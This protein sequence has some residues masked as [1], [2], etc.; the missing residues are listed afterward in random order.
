MS[1]V[2]AV[3]TKKGKI[4][5]D[6]ERYRS[7]GFWSKALE[8]ILA[9]GSD[10]STSLHML[11]QLILCENEL[12]WNDQCELPPE[13]L[14]KAKR[15]AEE[16]MK[17]NDEQYKF[18]ASVLL[19]K[20]YYLQG[21][22]EKALK[23]LSSL[24]LLSA[25]MDPITL[26]FNY[27]VSEGL[28]V[29]GLCKEE[30][31]KLKSLSDISK[32][33]DNIINLFNLACHMCIKH[34]Q[35]LDRTQ[36]EHTNSS[37]SVPPIVEKVIQKIPE[38]LLKKGDIPGAISKYRTILG[39]CELPATRSL[40]RAL[41]LRFS[42]LLLRSVCIK[43]YHKYNTSMDQDSSTDKD[44]QLIPYR[45][46]TNRYIPD[47]RIEEAIFSLM[48]SEHIASQ[49]VI[50]NR[51][52]ELSE[53]QIVRSF[54]NAA[55]VYDLLAILLTKVKHFKFLSKCLEKALKFSYHQF[56][57]W[58][59]FA[60]SL[61]SSKQYYRGYLALREC[62]RIDNSKISV[63]LFASSL[64][65]GHLN[66]IEEGMEL[67]S[68]AVE[69]SAQSETAFMARAHLLV[70]WGWS[71]L[72][73]SC[74][75]VDKKSELRNRAVKEYRI[76]IQLDPDDYLGWYH[77]AV[78]LATQRH[79]DE[80]LSICQQSLQLMPI[81][82]NTLYLLALLHT[83]GGKRLDQAAK[84]L[85]VGLSDRPND[86]N[87]LFLLAKI[88]EARINPKAGLKVYRQLLKVWRDTFSLGA[89]SK[90]IFNRIRK[91]ALSNN[92]DITNSNT[93]DDL[94]LSSVS[95][96]SP[97]L[98]LDDDCSILNVW[99]EKTNN[100]NYLQSALSDI[101]IG[102]AGQTGASIVPLP[103]QSRP[104]NQ[105]QTTALKVQIK[106]Y[107]GLAES[108][109]DNNQL[110]E[111]KEALDEVMKIGGLDNQTL[112][113]RGRLAEERGLVCI[114]RSLYES[115]IALKPDHLQ[116]LLSLASLLHKNNQTTLAERVARDAM[117][118]DPTS[119]RVWRLLADILGSSNTPEPASDAVVTRALLT[120]I[121][122]EQT[123][124]IEPFY[125]LPLGVRCN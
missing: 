33:R 100:S 36:P 9:H 19:G 67:A 109:L 12:E 120:A 60:L 69:V 51:P 86:F 93:P 50:L 61:I 40:R 118:V 119:F 121:E 81:H 72:A 31:S 95:S 45:Y 68:Q 4:E 122:L 75:V 76:A 92:N 28:A 21:N 35:E 59:Q 13:N 78:E 108:Y 125:C 17:G 11:N 97:S 87:L 25:K 124:P 105:N 64:C 79:L 102:C 26:R 41:S 83:A 46:P 74:C 77:L 116:A 96:F 10:R 71:I 99:E 107:Q 112:Y 62:L 55:A 103:R 110:F 6:V 43:T 94:T 106:I 27:I 30:Q 104:G 91:A 57:I 42:E 2:K 80:A 3:K 123:E 88:E 84:A 70:G 117:N 39:Y 56:H 115:V 85:Y 1:T 7:E 82:S 48:I 111:A 16:V 38:I 52:S 47:N 18:E 29:L 66:L 65:L 44:A 8:V 22:S 54:N 37:V 101:A 34:L 14:S 24:N 32:E 5:I 58:Y 49:D 15:Y 90:V 53:P 23:L 20:I 114:A 98:E 73:R 89:N 113:L 63:Y